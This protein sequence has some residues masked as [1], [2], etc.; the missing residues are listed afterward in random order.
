MRQAELSRAVKAASELLEERVEY[1]PS[2][3]ETVD[4]LL[5]GGFPKGKISEVTGPASSGR[6][7]LVFSALAH[8]TSAGENVAYIDTFNVFDPVSA[9]QSGIPLSRLLWIRCN[10]SA[11]KAA[12]AADIMARA[13]GFGMLVW[14]TAPPDEQSRQTAADRPPSHAWFRLKQAVEAS[15]CLLLVLSLKP[16][17]GPAASVV[18]NVKRTKAVWEPE[19]APEGR[20]SLRRPGLFKGLVFEAAMQRGKSRGYARVYSR[21]SAD[22]PSLLNLAHTLTPRVEINPPDALILE[23]TPRSRAGI[24][25]KLRNFPASLQT[26]GASTRSAALITARMN[27]GTWVPQGKEAEFLA[28]LPVALLRLLDDNPQLPEFLITFS[29]WGIRSLGDLAALPEKDLAARLG[30]PALLLQKLARGED[31]KPFQAEL[32]GHPFEA[33]VDLEYALDSL[34][35][36]SFILAGLLDPLCAELQSANLA[37]DSVELEIRLETRTTSRRKFQLAYPLSHARTILAL[38]RLELQ[39]QTEKARITGALIRLNPVP[40][41]VWQHSLFEPLAP[42]PEKLART[43]GRLAA[44][45]GKENVGSPVLLDTRRPDAF[46]LTGFQPARGRPTASK[47]VN[48]PVLRRFRPPFP[49]RIRPEQTANWV[50]PWRTSGEWWTETTWDH[51]EWDVEFTNGTVYRVFFDRKRRGWFLEGVYD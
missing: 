37:T 19:L 46:Q 7:S 32:P 34:E 28:P 16:S 30:Q 31:L 22:L 14:D 50:G 1:L 12:A 38:L 4:H 17:A 18:L 5:A 8:A 23:V 36:L 39:N 26:G 49:A 43:L 29:R 3:L 9:A 11:E 6:T 15:R 20:E 25:E 47:E 10:G 51:D 45:V 13:G 27:P 24:V 44:L 33:A 48:R 21:F 2:G 35:P 41:R 40:S 42:A